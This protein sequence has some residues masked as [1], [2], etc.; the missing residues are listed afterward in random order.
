MERSSPNTGIYH[1]GRCNPVLDNEG[2]MSRIT[3][4]LTDLGKWILESVAFVIGFGI[5]GVI[6][7]FIIGFIIAVIKG[8]LTL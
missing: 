4:E 3:R 8:D 1:N 7:A 6:V 5:I 2:L